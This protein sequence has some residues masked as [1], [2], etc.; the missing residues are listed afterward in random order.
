MRA[1]PLELVVSADQGSVD[2]APA[3]RDLT[4]KVE[5]VR[6]YLEGLQRCIERLSAHAVALLLTELEAAYTAGRQVFII[7]NGGSAATASHLACDLSK[8]I[9]GGRNDLP[10]F[11]V[12]S[13]GD[14]V[15]LLTAVGND[16]GYAELFAEQ[17][18]TWLD[19]GDL[20][21]VIS[22]SGNSP[23]VLSALHVARDR[24]ARTVGLLGFDGGRA[25]SLVDVCVHV[26]TNAYG[27]IE[28]QHVVIGHLAT[29]YMSMIVGESG[30]SSQTFV[31][32]AR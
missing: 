10:R 23:N 25:R 18:R 28:D 9:L 24:H 6:S 16:L 26:D 20:V 4:K 12:L 1:A 7:G 31:I 11:R 21:I 8:T 30:Q 3:E 5:F 17:L 15:P 22:G 32:G 29:A 14:N 2:P 27:F 13:L 19:P